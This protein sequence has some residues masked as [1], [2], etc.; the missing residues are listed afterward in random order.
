MIGLNTSKFEVLKYVGFFA[1]GCLLG[2]FLFGR[3]PHDVTPS[4]TIPASG[5]VSLQSSTQVSVE[6]KNVLDGKL[7]RTDLEIVSKPVDFTV[8]V[9]GQELDIKK[10]E[11][12][13]YVLEK[14][15][16]KVN[17]EL[18]GTYSLNIEPVYI[19]KTKHWGLGVVGGMV[20]SRPKFYGSVL[21][22]I[23]KRSNLDGQIITNGK[24]FLIGAHITF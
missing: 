4:N 21:F 3:N 23:N 1:V 15:K 18:K 12:E 24:D 8:K 2:F 17:T 7:E 6:P 9:N 11:N 19:D 5:E 22:P 20:D 14:N 10:E 16:I 13:S